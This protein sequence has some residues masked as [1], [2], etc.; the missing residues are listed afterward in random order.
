MFS[1]VKAKLAE[2]RKYC[3][4]RCNSIPS[5]GSSSTGPTPAESKQ[6]YNKAFDELEDAVNSYKNTAEQQTLVNIMSSINCFKMISDD[7]VTSVWTYYNMD[8]IASQI[9]DASLESFYSGPLSP[10]EEPEFSNTYTRPLLNIIPS[11]EQRRRSASTQYCEP[12]TREIPKV[13][14]SD[15]KMPIIQRTKS[16]AASFVY[17]SN[18][19]QGHVAE[20][21]RD[22][23]FDIFIPEGF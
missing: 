22:Y 9:L 1:E 17:G 7:P 4:Q 10:S 18:E 15:Y 2:A 8:G 6:Q 14:F 5:Y 21:I 23:G 16:E 11:S 20:I 3:I 13:M 19:G 12:M